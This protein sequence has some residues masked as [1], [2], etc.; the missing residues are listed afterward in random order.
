M[1]YQRDISCTKMALIIYNVFLSH[2]QCNVDSFFLFNLKMQLKVL[3]F[4]QTYEFSDFFCAF[5]N[6]FF[7]FVFFNFIHIPFKFFFC[8]RNVDQPLSLPR[9]DTAEKRLT[10]WQLLF[11]LVIYCYSSEFGQ[12]PASVD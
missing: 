10:Q 1:G 12:L 5:A 9:F 2:T 6:C 3:K 11:V 7:L 8:C 4:Y